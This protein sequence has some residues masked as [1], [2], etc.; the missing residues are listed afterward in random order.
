MT[1]KNYLSVEQM[2]ISAF[3]RQMMVLKSVVTIDVMVLKSV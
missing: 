3:D 2:R 1:R